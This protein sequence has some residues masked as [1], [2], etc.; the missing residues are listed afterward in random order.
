MNNDVL[1]TESVRRASN[2]LQFIYF[3]IVQSRCIWQLQKNTTHCTERASLQKV[4]DLNS[5]QVAFFPL[6][7]KYIF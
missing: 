3:I 5:T 1:H 6:I 2:Q 4:T 7:Y